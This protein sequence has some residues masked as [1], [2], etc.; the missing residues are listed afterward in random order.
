MQVMMT[1]ALIATLTQSRASKVI[2]G[3]WLF[4]LGDHYTQYDDYCTYL[5]CKQMLHKK[6]LPGA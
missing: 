2:L 4:N 6:E 1:T 3:P 5:N